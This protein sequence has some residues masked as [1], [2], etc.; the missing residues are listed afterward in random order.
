MFTALQY[1]I[2]KRV[3]P[4]EPG[5]M[6]GAAYSG[7]SKL[8]VLLGDH[9]FSQ[10]EGRTVIDFGCG[11]GADA[12]EMARS[13]ARAVIGVDIRQ[14]ALD[15]ATAL[16]QSAGV[17]DRCRF[18][19]EPSESADVIVSLDSFEHFADPQAILQIMHRWL[20]PGGRV[21]TSFGPTWYHPYGGHLFSVF[22]WAHLIFSERALIRWRSD[23]RSDGARKFSEVEGGLNQ[24]TIGRFTRLVKASPF[25][26]ESIQTVP[27]RKLKPVHNRITREFTTAIVRAT[28]VKP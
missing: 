28:L 26:I 10:I 6:S 11:D 16:A 13:G 3:A 14:D 23:I 4:G 9:L 27:I 15:R 2:L 8:K 19:L 22:P 20:A 18:A 24:M 12:V 17:A 25:R 1:Q 5:C 7:K 21:I